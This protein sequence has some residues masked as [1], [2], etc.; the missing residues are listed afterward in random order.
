MSK[1]K[2]TGQ[3]VRLPDPAWAALHKVKNDLNKDRDA[4]DAHAT[5]S[6]V[7]NMAVRD[8]LQK[9]GYDVYSRSVA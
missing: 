4:L 1:V 9:H 8:F 2:N 5:V 7:I 3:T 6:V